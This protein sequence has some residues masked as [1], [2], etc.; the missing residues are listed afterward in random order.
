[1]DTRAEEL[2]LSIET[3]FYKVTEA[4]LKETGEHLKIGTIE[5]L[6]ER[7]L[8]RKIRD[9]L[10]EACEKGKYDSEELESLA[11]MYSRTSHR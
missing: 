11:L 4:K 1:M 5:S 9:C 3:T 6:S 7:I 10:D 8:I 2:M